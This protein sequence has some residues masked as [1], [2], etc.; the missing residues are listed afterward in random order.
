MA[1][2]WSGVSA[3]NREGAGVAAG[4]E[5]TVDIELDTAPREVTVPA[6][7]A[8]ALRRVPAAERNFDQL[9]YSNR[10]RHVLSIE[11]AKTAETRQRRI[12]KAVDALRTG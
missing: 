5:V 2:T 8:A 10:Q 9:S 3:E 12:A 1:N 11:Q 7:F 6:D 4:D